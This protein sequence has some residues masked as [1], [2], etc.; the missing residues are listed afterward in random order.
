MYTNLPLA[1]FGIIH[2]QPFNYV[3]KLVI[4]SILDEIVHILESLFEP[5]CV[6]IRFC[7]S[8]FLKNIWL[9]IKKILS[10]RVKLFIERINEL[11]KKKKGF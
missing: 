8:E 7:N 6:L 5:T 11:E 2:S 3:V 4:W 9:K 10:L 1:F